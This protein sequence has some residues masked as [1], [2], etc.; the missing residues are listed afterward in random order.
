MVASS[1]AFWQPSVWSNATTTSQLTLSVS[2]AQLA[3]RSESVSQGSTP[4]AAVA[5][6]RD[7]TQVVANRIR[8]MDFMVLPCCRRRS[9]TSGS[10]PGLCMRG[11]HTARLP[12]RNLFR[13]NAAVFVARHSWEVCSEPLLQE[14]D[15]VPLANP[16]QYDR[17]FL[18]VSSILR[19]FKRTV[20]PCG[21]IIPAGY[22]AQLRCR[23]SR[24]ARRAAADWVVCNSL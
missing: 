13:Q 15:S 23:P 10:L 9:R 6:I 24:T 11:R 22:V 3:Q 1:S 16:A 20:L 4:H 12:V 7:K 17:R 19:R 14:D 5:P 2:L 18:T 8:I 21:A